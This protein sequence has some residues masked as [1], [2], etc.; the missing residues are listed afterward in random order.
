MIQIPFQEQLLHTAFTCMA[1]DGHIDQKELD[2]IKNLENE[3]QLFGVENI[4]GVLRELVKSFQK[5]GKEFLRQYLISIG[6]SNF[7]EEEE[8]AIVRTAVTTIKADGEEKYSEI[9]FFK[10]IR[11]K[12]NVSDTSLLTALPEFENL[13][14]DYLQQDI[15][16][17]S[18]LE[19]LTLDYFDR[20]EMPT[21]EIIQS[22]LDKETGNQKDQ[23]KD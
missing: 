19:S 17:S 23:I 15:I 3:H 6:D 8:I 18:I 7:S 5:R 10:I 2:L 4:D 22:W 11:S 1:C 20:F 9:K 12:L 13:E 14:E 21:F 16:S